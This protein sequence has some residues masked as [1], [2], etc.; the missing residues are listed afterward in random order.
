MDNKTTAYS[1]LATG[2][3]AQHCQEGRVE[4][5]LISEEYKIPLLYLFKVLQKLTKANILHSKRGPGGGFTL[6]R[7]ATEITLLE[8]I[9]A[10]D[11]PMVNDLKLSKQ[12]NKKSFVLKMEKVCQSATAK[13]IEIYGKAKLSDMVK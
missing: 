3:I 8:I 13:E 6:T 7:P 5:S 2:Y 4:A 12:T 1:L 10:V 9:E 11:G